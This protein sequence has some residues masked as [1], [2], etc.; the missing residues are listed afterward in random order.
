MLHERDDLTNPLDV[1]G[2]RR[3][4]A[5]LPPGQSALD[6]EAALKVLDE[7]KLQLDMAESG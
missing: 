5:M 7:L 4:V 1:E 2:L 6:R 3:S